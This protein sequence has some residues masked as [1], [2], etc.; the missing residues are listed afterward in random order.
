VYAV[1]E[2]GGKQH[3]VAEG[4]HLKVELLPDEVGS[5][6]ETD[7]VLLIGGEK[8]VVGNPYVPNAKVGM[9]IVAHGRLPKVIIHKHI[10]RK[11]YHRTRGHRQHFSEVL[12]KS[13]NL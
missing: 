6:I 7:K 5:T 12:I 13:I 3:R 4:D 2:M 1:I 8:T 10:R 11:G 9:E